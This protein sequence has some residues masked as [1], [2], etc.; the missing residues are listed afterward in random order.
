MQWS[1]GSGV[2][3]P[4]AGRLD[5]EYRHHFYQATGWQEEVGLILPVRGGLTLM[6]F[7]GRL[8]KRSSLSRDELTRLEALFPLVHSLCRQHWRE[9]TPRL[10]RSPARSDGTDL[11]GRW[12]RL[13]PVWGRSANPAGA[14][15][16][17]VCCCRGWIPRPLPVRSASA[18]AR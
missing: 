12:S 7:L 4:A 2:W 14:P 1:R 13:S 9:E 3:T 15:G 5:P 11:K 18:A 10:A 8:D 17:G 6:L 16:G